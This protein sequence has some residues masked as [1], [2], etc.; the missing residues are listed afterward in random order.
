MK[1]IISKTDKVFQRNPL[2]QLWRFVIMGLQF[3]KLVRRT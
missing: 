1:Y 2:W 3:V